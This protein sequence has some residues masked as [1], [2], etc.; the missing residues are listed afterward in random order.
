MHEAKHKLGGA[1]RLAMA[2]NWPAGGI[3]AGAGRQGHRLGCPGRQDASLGIKWNFLVPEMYR[4]LHIS[5]TCMTVLR[6]FTNFGDI[7]C[8]QD[9]AYFRYNFLYS[10]KFHVPGT[11]HGYAANAMYPVHFM[12]H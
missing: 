8:L 11:F 10:P 1:A 7:S 4:I 3:Q 6:K 2:L 12:L 9:R 5:C